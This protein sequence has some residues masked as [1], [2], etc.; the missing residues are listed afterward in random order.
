MGNLTLGEEI[1]FLVIMG[2]AA[3]GLWNLAGLLW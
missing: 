1:W 2:L 3:F